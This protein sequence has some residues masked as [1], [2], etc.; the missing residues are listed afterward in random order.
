MEVGKLEILNMFIFV[1]LFLF[2]F[3]FCLFFFFFWLY[4]LSGVVAGYIYIIYD[5]FFLLT[6]NWLKKTLNFLDRLSLIDFRLK[7]EKFILKICIFINEKWIF[8]LKI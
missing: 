4:F 7:N 5:N 3:C 8:Y 6:K 2:F 1:P